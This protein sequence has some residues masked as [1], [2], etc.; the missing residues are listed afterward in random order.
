MKKLI[1]GGLFL[2]FSLSA[3]AQIEDPEP[4][5][6]QDYFPLSISQEQVLVEPNDDACDY[7]YS[8]GGSTLTINCDVPISGSTCFWRGQGVYKRRFFGL[9]YDRISRDTFVVC[10]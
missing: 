10:P 5:T 6:V 1:L 8:S 3:M 4:I 7:I 9:W 2:L